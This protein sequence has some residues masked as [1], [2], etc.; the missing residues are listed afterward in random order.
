MGESQNHFS[1]QQRQRWSGA[2]RVG[3]A[4]PRKSS[5]APSHFSGGIWNHNSCALPSTQLIWAIARSQS[6]KI[7]LVNKW[8]QASLLIA[9]VCAVF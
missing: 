9:C 1:K 7:W 8:F 2:E 6:E 3:L 5:V 4:L